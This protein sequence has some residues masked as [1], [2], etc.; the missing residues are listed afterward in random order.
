MSIFQLARLYRRLR[1]K[2]YVGLGTIVGLL[3]IAILGNSI[4]FY[5]FDGPAYAEAGTPLTVEDTLWY[6]VISM[7]TIGYGD[8][9]ATNRSERI[10]V[11]FSMMIC[12][13]IFA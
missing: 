12:A 10:Y 7:T 9:Y 2:R 13:L 11:T 5:V 3:L 4:C 8:I 1:F 6:S